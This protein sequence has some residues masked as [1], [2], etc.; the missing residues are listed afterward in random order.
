[1]IDGIFRI[2]YE[3]LPSSIEDVLPRYDKCKLITF[4]TPY[5]MTL[6]DESEYDLYKE[7]DYIASDGSYALK[8][9][10][11]VGRPKS[12]R[13]SFDMTSVAPIVFSDLIKNKRGLYVLGA[14]PGEV[15]Q[16]VNTIRTSFPDLI[17]SGYHHGYIKDD[18][19]SVL[20]KVIESKA[21]VC[22]VG[23]GAPLQDRISVKLKKRGFIGTVYTCGGFIHQSTVKMIS[24]PRWA[25]RYNIR[26]FY[27]WFHERGIFARAPR[28]LWGC[29][30][31][32]WW[33]I[34][35]V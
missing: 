32:G 28:Q 24:Y 9:G 30:R 26:F 15:E 34:K 18:E 16:A 3:K 5:Y 11:W 22:I 27:R 35:N 29:L 10:S 7:F 19:D 23:M 31:Y 8:V 33:L 13:L 25:D 14:K 12:L 17:V 1:M 2:F 6:L 20:Q 4:L 21:G